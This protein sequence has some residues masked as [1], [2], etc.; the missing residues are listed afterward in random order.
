MRDVS[1]LLLIKEEA[2]IWADTKAKQLQAILPTM[3]IFRV[4]SFSLG[5]CPAFAG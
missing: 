2:R 3:E 5:A 4:S 1:S